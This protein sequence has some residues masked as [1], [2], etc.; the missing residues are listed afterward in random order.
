MPV[1]PQGPVVIVNVLFVIFPIILIVSS[2]CSLLWPRMMWYLSRGRKFK[3]AEP[4]GCVL[5]AIRVRGLLGLF[6][7]F[8]F[9]AVLWGLVQAQ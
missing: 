3:N 1:H 8:L 4:S 9:L 5:V 7:G 2:L 6:M